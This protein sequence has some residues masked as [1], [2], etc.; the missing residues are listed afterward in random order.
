M[1]CGR[2]GEYRYFDM[3]QAI[4]G[5]LRIARVVLR[6]SSATSSKVI[7][8]RTAQSEH[9]LNAGRVVATIPRRNSRLNDTL[10]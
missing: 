5:A 3:D 2:L 6:T 9:L 10:S 8:Q 1:I 7:G 4:G